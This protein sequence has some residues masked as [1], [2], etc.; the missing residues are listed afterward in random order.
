ME[1]TAATSDPTLEVPPAKLLRE[2][3]LWASAAVFVGVVVGLAGTFSMAAWWV[4]ASTTS[5]PPALGAVGYWG[6][7][8]AAL[9][10][11]GVPALAK[12]GQRSR[13]LQVGTGLLLASLLLWL[14]VI[15]L[16]VLWPPPVLTVAFVATTVLGIAATLSLGLGA[17]FSGA[18]GLLRI[19]TGLLL[20]SLLLWLAARLVPLRFP[21]LWTPKGPPTP[22]LNV[23]FVATT[24][25][26]IAAT[27][28]LGLGAFFS[29]ARRL[30]ALL[31]ILAVPAEDL[32]FSA[33][34]ALT[35]IDWVSGQLA[36]TTTLLFGQG[37]GVPEAC[38]FAL[39]GAM[40]LGGARRRALAKAEE[41]NRGKALRLYEVGLGKNDPSVV[42]EVVSKDFRDPRRGLSGKGGMK[43]IC[44]DLWASYPDL[45]VSVEGQE[46]EGD[47][48]RTRVVLSGTDRGGGVMWYPPTGR[49]VSFEA[50]FTDR[51]RGGEVVEHTGWV[52]TE[53]L[54]RQLGHHRES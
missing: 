48:V 14:A 16:P 5:G 12:L 34:Y 3:L 39:L 28:S 17:F 24:V 22:V 30:G 41:E 35:G 37:P 10:L 52:D 11:L 21:S 42:E 4:D 1:A 47:V 53:G 32:F 45:D 46:A 33:R 9:S 15:L 23:V 25:L 6:E 50:E 19:G 43:R 29:G 40:L 49:W 26:G 18:R 20:A 31:L 44:A 7:P 27:L 54:L 8:L 13:A 36:A 51:F 38:L 2:P